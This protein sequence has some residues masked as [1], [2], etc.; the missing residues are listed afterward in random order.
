MEQLKIG[1]LPL[2]I[3]LY[4]DT[5][6]E[7]KP[8]NEKY[9][10]KIAS[11]FA[12]RG[13][14]VIRAPVCRLE[15]E[16]RQAVAAFEENEADAVVT[17][18]LAYSPSLESA[19]VLAGTDLPIVVLDTTP[20]FECA[21]DSEFDVIKFNHGIHGV[22]DMCNLLRR[23]KKEFCIVAG[24]PASSDVIGRAVEAVKAARIARRMKHARVGIVGEKFAGMGDFQVP[25]DKLKKL[26]GMEVVE[27]DPAADY[28]I[29]AE[30]IGE[31]YRQC[32]EKYDVT[33]DF[34]TFARIEKVGLGVRRWVRENRLTGL[35]MSFSAVK[36][37]QFFD[38][39]P[40][41]EACKSMENG[42]GY[43]G[44][45]DVLTAALVGALL[46]VYEKTTFCEMFCPDWKNGNIFLSHMGEFNPR[47][48]KVRPKL[49]TKPF[50]YS[51][52]GYATF[53]SSPMAAGDAL[54]VTLLPEPDDGFTI[55][56]AG[57][58][59]LDVPV[60][61]TFSGTVNGW[62]RPRMPVA[63]FLAAYSENG[64]IHHFAIAY[65]ADP[66]VIGMFAGHMGW[67][68]KQLC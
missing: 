14:G 36:D 47:C 63:D 27:F 13:V 1:L 57:A 6:P 7:R 24:H 10:D 5:T 41:C 19:G 3:K 49:I 44:E 42:T 53:L 58:E 35:T 31:E 17:L 30:E 12:E 23:N 9:V 56:C 15:S 26:I 64:G 8:V 21:P 48:A 18:H 51:G 60:D 50:I 4:D 66:A 46:G 25:Y 68:F 40:F 22:Q 37:G 61:N 29:S 65:G 32:R 54:T 43:A 55:L 59:M 11:Y 38:A 45:G 20:S 33:V 62:F 2:Y 16:F 34:D 67:G 39:M 28:D 52:V